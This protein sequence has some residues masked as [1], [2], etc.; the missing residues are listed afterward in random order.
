MRCK[1]LLLPLIVLFTLAANAQS[2]PLQPPPQSPRQALLEM[3]FGSAPNHL[4]K[5]LPEIARKAFQQLDSGAG[6]SFLGEISMIASQAR[7]LGSSFQTFDSG[8]TLLLA[9]EPPTQQKIEVLVEQDN[10][11]G[12]ENQIDLSFRMYRSGLE[13]RLPIIPRLTFMMKPEKGV[14]KL[15]EV[16]F[17]A[18]M[19]LGDP[20]F[21]KGFVKDLKKKQ[22][23]SNESMAS[24]SIR[25]IVSAEN[26]YH[27]AHSERG[28]SCSLS[29]LAQASSEARAQNN[30]AQ[31]NNVIALDSKLVSGKKNGYVFALTGCDSLHYKVAAEPATPAAGQ[32]AYC[33]DESGEIKFASDGKATTCLSRGQSLNDA[34]SFEGVSID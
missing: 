7:A 33:A 9:E 22:Q 5:H 27:L 6:Q 34:N 21:L 11:V 31:N 14:W 12:E 18:R 4:E 16:S 13:E 10:L 29:E 25:T 8:P 15:N 30:S 2:E 1:I 3:F 26:A 20:D 28:Y 19:P 23:S 24:W 17:T 32:R